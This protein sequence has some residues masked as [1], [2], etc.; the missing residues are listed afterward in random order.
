MPFRFFFF[1]AC[2][3]MLTSGEAGCADSLDLAWGDTSGGCRLAKEAVDA[4]ASSGTNWLTPSRTTSGPRCTSSTSSGSSSEGPS[5][6]SAKKSSCLLESTRSALLCEGKGYQVGPCAT[7]PG[8]LRTRFCASSA[9]GFIV[10]KRVSENV[11]TIA[12]FSRTRVLRTSCEAD[13]SLTL[14]GGALKAFLRS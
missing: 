2:V 14:E 6:I 3:C 5:V 11:R 12:F 4:G 8:C 13:G 9:C 7:L 10:S 1:G